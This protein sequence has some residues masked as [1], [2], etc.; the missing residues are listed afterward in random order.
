MTILNNT[1][2]CYIAIL[3]EQLWLYSKKQRQ[4]RFDQPGGF[5]G[6]GGNFGGRGGGQGGPGN[7]MFNGGPGGMGGGNPSMRGGD[8][9]REEPG[10]PRDDYGDMKRMRRYWTRVRQSL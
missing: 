4:S 3:D 2:N 6:N 1:N 8:R 7:G 9:R 10:G 5:G